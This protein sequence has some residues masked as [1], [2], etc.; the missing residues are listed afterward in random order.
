MSDRPWY[1]GKTTWAKPTEEEQLIMGQSR[2][3]SPMIRAALLVGLTLTIAGCGSLSDREERIFGQRFDTRVPLS[4]TLPNA[5]G[6]V[7]VIDPADVDRAAP[8]SLPGQ[9]QIAAWPQRG[10]N[11]QNRIPHAAF[12][13]QGQVWAVD[14]GAGNGRR[15]RLTADPVAGGGRIFA[16]D[17]QGQVTAV[18]EAGAV[19]WRADLT[20]GFDRGGGISGGG[21]ALDGATLYAA[22]GYGE[23]VALEA[24]SGAVR[25]RQRLDA[26]AT[27]PTVAGGLVYVVS[28]DNQAWAIDAASGRVRW[29]LQTAPSGAVLKGGAAPAVGNGTVIFPFGTGEIIAASAGAGVRSWGTTVAGER[30]GVAYANV[31]DITGDPLIVGGTAY[32]GNQSGRVVALDVAS[33]N[34]LWTAQDGAYSPLLQAGGALFFVSDRNELLRLDAASGERVWGSE[35]PLFVNARER[36]RRAVFTHF[37]PILAGGQLVVASGD[38]ALRFFDPTSGAQTR[39]IS[40]RGGAA[41]NPIVMNGTLYVISE[42]GRLLAFR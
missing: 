34:R 39:E 36:R 8:I 7:P 23:V 31:N 9:Q 28:R 16:L 33:G 15:T 22:T 6:E 14:I 1:V 25:W 4:T 42:S 41:S 38:G 30:R 37:G 10:A 26:G 18:S 19:L 12:A 2:H 21:L 3:F 17:A 27:T 5:A 13:G 20:A 35:L 32:A 11:A 40:F 24:A 29:Q